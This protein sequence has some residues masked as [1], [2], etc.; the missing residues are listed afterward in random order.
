MGRGGI[1]TVWQKD[2]TTGP[3]GQG[4]EMQNAPK[5]PLI[6]KERVVNEPHYECGFVGH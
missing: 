5:N 4:N 3:S 6:K 2:G 1:S